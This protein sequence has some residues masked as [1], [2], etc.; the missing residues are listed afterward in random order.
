MKKVCFKCG[1]TKVKSLFYKHKGMADGVLGKCKTC[2]KAD[3]SKRYHDPKNRKK[4]QTY[5]RE[6]FKDPK[7]K[8]KLLEYQ[9]NR[10]HKNRG[11][12]MARV[13]VYKAIMKGHI[14]KE[15]CMV[16]GRSAQAHHKDYRKPLD[17][18]WLCFKHHREI[19]GQKVI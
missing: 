15:S 4:I 11:K 16:C 3:V 13:K 9:R 2:T 5:E 12:N 10:R 8:K 6:R 1:K 19:H 18:V 7:R 14:K 17:I